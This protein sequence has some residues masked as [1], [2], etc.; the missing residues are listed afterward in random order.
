[1]AGTLRVAI[2]GAGGIGKHHAKWYHQ[3]ACEVVGFWGSSEASCAA[4]TQALKE[5]FDF[6]GKGY[7]NLEQLL[8]QEQPDLVDV[9]VPDEL[10]FDCALSALEAGCHVLCEKPLVWQDGQR[11]EVLL[12]RARVLVD[13]ARVKGLQFG[14][15]TQYAASLPHYL[16]LYEP[17]L[18]NLQGISSFYA[19]METG[20]QAR[21]RDAAAVWVDMG[22]HPLSLLLS[23]MPD[24]VIDT[25]SVQVEFAGNEASAAF[26]FVAGK[27]TCHSEIIVR[28]L[29]AGKPVRRFGVNGVV[30]DCEG[31]SDRDGV[32][33]AVLR[34]GEREVVGDDFMALLIAR[35]VES[36]KDSRKRPLVSGEAGRRNLEL[37]LE[38]L[39][40]VHESGKEA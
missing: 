5:I 6:R 11:P 16:H 25:D 8:D 3:A 39:Q 27:E 28:D 30:V 35:F 14:V 20:A 2:A 36:I 12:E 26:D 15:C 31:R 10:H 7:R 22:P 37:Q 18:G 17:A 32:Y 9:C 19:E 21:S 4:T 29:E 23:W 33:Q 1:M 34:R 38:I 40:R 24:G 13:T